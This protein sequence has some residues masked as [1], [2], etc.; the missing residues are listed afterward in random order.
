[1][2]RRKMFLNPIINNSLYIILMSLFIGWYQTRYLEGLASE[3]K[4]MKWFVLCSY[5]YLDAYSIKYV[6]PVFIWILSQLYLV[7]LLGNFIYQDVYKNAVYIF[8]RT[9]HRTLWFFSNI[10][11]LF[12]Y[13]LFYYCIHFFIN[14]LMAI[15]KGFTLQNY[16]D[17]IVIGLTFLLQVFVSYLLVLM[18]NVFTLLFQN[19]YAYV[20]VIAGYIFL[21]MLTG[22]L[23]EFS[24]R[25]L[26]IAEWFP[27]SHSILAWHDSYFIKELQN[28]FAIKY[29]DG[30][31]IV[32]SFVYI[33]I[34]TFVVI[35]FAIKRFKNMDLI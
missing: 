27:F 26:F 13:V 24:S 9:N 5:G 31:S 29:F 21:I 2:Y 33:I 16:Q 23:A 18:I 11:W 4:S 7:Y 28:L 10:S 6:F 8:T 14:I 35:Y 17:L 3:Y 22:M 19:T 32:Q 30:F 20:V 34:F 15:V 1:M 25:Y 12:I